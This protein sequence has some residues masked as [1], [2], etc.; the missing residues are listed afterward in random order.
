M[1]KYKRY[2]V[3]LGGFEIIVADDEVADDIADLIHENVN[4]CEADIV[5]VK[6]DKELTLDEVKAS[7]F[8]LQNPICC[9]PKVQQEI[10][11]V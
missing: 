8:Y 3:E 10:G 11:E 6:F 1:T 9:S 4:E 5:D 7:G 2:W